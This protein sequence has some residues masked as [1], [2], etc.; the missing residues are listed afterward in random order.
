MNLGEAMRKILA[1]GITFG[2]ELGVRFIWNDL[3]LRGKLEGFDL[4]KDSVG[5]FVFGQVEIKAQR[6]NW[7][8]VPNFTGKVWAP[9]YESI[10]SIDE[11]KLVFIFSDQLRENNRNRLIL[12]L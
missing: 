8:E 10:E 7:S 1:N 5:E 3:E 6:G 12:T 4:I 11:N 9:I 2:K